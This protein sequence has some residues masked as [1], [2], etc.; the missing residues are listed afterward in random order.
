MDHYTTPPRQV[1]APPVAVAVV[2]ARME[3]Q[4]GPV[5]MAAAAAAADMVAR[6][7]PEA[8]AAV[9]VVEQLQVP[10]IMGEMVGG[11]PLEYSPLSLVHN[12]QLQLVAE[13]RQMRLEIAH[14]G[15][16][17]FAL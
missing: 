1:T 15:A 17:A 11:L 16:R 9:A 4:Q 5:A 2:L 14:M 10:D 8:L 6:P 12:L 13:E 7:D 3:E